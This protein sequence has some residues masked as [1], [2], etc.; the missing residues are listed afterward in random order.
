MAMDGWFVL[1]A[2]ADDIFAETA[3][4]LWRRVLARQDGPLR[5]FASFPE[6]PSV[7]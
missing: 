4:E 7:N 2:E 1:D 3:D 6:D 5:R